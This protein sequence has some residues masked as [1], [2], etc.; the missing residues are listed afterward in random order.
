MEKA[1]F[2]VIEYVLNADNKYY[3]QTNTHPEGP[4]YYYSK[5][6][7]VT[8][9]KD[10]AFLFSSMTDRDHLSK[11]FSEMMEATNVGRPPIPPDLLLVSNS[12]AHYFADDGERQYVTDI[13]SIAKVF[14][15]PQDAESMKEQ[16]ERL[17]TE[18]GLPAVAC[19]NSRI[20]TRFAA[21]VDYNRRLEEMRKAAPTPQ[22]P[23]YLIRFLDPKQENDLEGDETPCWVRYYCEGTLVTSMEAAEWFGRSADV[24][25]VANELREAALAEQMYD[26]SDAL[27]LKLRLLA[28]AG[29]SPSINGIQLTF[30]DSVL[31]QVLAV[32]ELPNDS[33]YKWDTFF[34]DG[35]RWVFDEEVMPDEDE[36]DHD[37]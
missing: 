34:Q 12:G 32:T 14:R 28:I 6:G 2:P 37:D 30:R 3:I 10:E 26:A 17:L 31:I 24:M 7:L 33:G 23:S 15:A 4:T 9:E 8:R 11:I 19:V 13:L 29:Q 16:F 21:T 22:E 35:L 18:A 20:Q 27:L 5:D 36:E 25:L 1:I